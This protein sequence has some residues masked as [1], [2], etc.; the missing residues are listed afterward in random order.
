MVSLLCCNHI[1]KQCGDFRLENINF[2]LEQG[3]ILGVIGVNGVGKT[4]LLRSILG[5]YRLD[6]MG[7]QGSV[8]IAGK[9]SVKDIV[10][11]KE[12]IAYVL[13]DTPF[14]VGMTALEIGRIYGRYYKSFDMNKYI[15]LLREYQVPYENKD[16]YRAI[17]NLSKGQQIRQQLAFAQ[18]YDARLFIFDEATGNLDVNFREDLYKQIREIVSTGE[19]SVIYATHL[20]EE[21]E[22]FADYILWLQKEHNVGYARYFGT[23]DDL[24]NKYRMVEADADTMDMVEQS[25]VVGVRNT[26]THKEALISVDGHDIPEHLKNCLR[27]AEL[28]EIMYYVEKREVAERIRAEG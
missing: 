9:D 19:K 7:S 23:I 13:Q 14:D 1:S 28:K 25:M 12:Q 24:K 8:T 15:S 4:T 20:V 21:M 16:K 2:Q 10:E 6:G 11:Y 5:S 22:E 18:A 3:Y 17:N 26:Q 27:Y